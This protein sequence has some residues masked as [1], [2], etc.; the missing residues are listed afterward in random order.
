DG[1][2][3]AFAAG[4]FKHLR[5]DGLD[6]TVP[7]RVDIAFKRGEDG[8]VRGVWQGVPASLPDGLR[9]FTRQWTRLPL[10]ANEGVLQR[11]AE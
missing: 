2:L 8:R 6:V 9:A 7:E 1:S 3:A 11:T 4:G 10:P 5:V